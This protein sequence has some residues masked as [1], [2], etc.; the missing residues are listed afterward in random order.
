M[1]AYFCL[2]LVGCYSKSLPVGIFTWSLHL[3]YVLPKSIGVF[4]LLPTLTHFRQDSLQPQIKANCSHKAISLLLMAENF[5]KRGHLPKDSVET[6]KS[7]CQGQKFYFHSQ[8]WGGSVGLALHHSLWCDLPPWWLAAFCPL[9]AAQSSCQQAF[10]YV[11]R[12]HPT[13]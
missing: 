6:E 13:L 1:V 10:L 4:K 11:L 5:C 12:F 3:K 9:L 2:C 7:Y 8:A